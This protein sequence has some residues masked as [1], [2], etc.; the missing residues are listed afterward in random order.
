MGIKFKVLA[1]I[2]TVVVLVGAFMLLRP[3]PAA[4]TST[5]KVTS[6][7]STGNQAHKQIFDF[8]LTDGKVS[9]G[10][11]SLKVTK[12]DQVTVNV[13]SDKPQEFHLHGYDKEIELEPGKTGNISFT[14][15]KTGQF[16]AELHGS[17]QQIFVL[18]VQP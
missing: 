3:Q 9:K 16:E 18:E 1:V 10:Q 14:A 11:T 5:T 13:I 17:K 6:D 12:G 7:R 4:Q 15:D 8:E 2:A